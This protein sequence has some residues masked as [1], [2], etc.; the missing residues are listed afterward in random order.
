MR[1][2]IKNVLSLLLIFAMVI[3]TVI[4]A[5]KNASAAIRIKNQNCHTDSN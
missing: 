2:T 5:P 4:L 1:K 3:S